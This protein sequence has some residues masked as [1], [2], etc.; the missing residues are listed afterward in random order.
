MLS[1]AVQ[2]N[3][4]QSEGLAHPGDG[5]MRCINPAVDT[6]SNIKF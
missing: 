3:L 1:G 5:S 4:T 2:G 6:F